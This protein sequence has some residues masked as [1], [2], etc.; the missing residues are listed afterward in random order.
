MDKDEDGIG[1]IYAKGNNVMLGYYKDSAKTKDAFFDGWFKTGDLGFI[2]S[3]GF[4]HISGRKKNVII[5]KSGKNVFPEEI[6]DQLN[7]SPFILECLVYGE[8]SEKQDE[9]IAAQIVVD[10]EAFI[11]FSQEN[12]VQIT[13]D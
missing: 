3:D 7:H 4:L 11:L 13:D 5:S 8:K 6:E 1:E 12:N 10:A 9:I 2:D